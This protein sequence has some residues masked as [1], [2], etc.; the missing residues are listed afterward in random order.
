MNILVT[1]FS[2]V[3]QAK[4]QKKI[5]EAQESELQ[6]LGNQQKTICRP[7]RS[8]MDMYLRKK[9]EMP[10]Y[11]EYSVWQNRVD[12]ELMAVIATCNLPYYLV[13]FEGFK[14]F[15]PLIS[16]QWP[17]TDLICDYDLLFS[18]IISN[19]S[20]NA[21]KWVHSWFVHFYL[22]WHVWWKPFDTHFQVLL[23]CFK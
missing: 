18:T 10:K 8:T 23:R 17:S 19:I 1:I 7:V 3:L 13:D 9:V 14:H 5:Y 6:V 12:L 15:S 20:V 11:K 22:I 2:N 4:M 16:H 21:L